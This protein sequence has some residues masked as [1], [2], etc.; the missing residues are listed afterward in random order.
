MKSRLVHT[1]HLYHTELD[2]SRAQRSK[3]ALRRTCSTVQ[4]KIGTQ[5]CTG[6]LIVWQ[7]TGTQ[8]LRIRTKFTA[9]P[10]SPAR[11]LSGCDPHFR[12]SYGVARCADL[13]GPRAAGG[14]SVCCSRICQFC[15]PGYSVG[16]ARAEFAERI[17]K[18]HRI[19]EHSEFT[20]HLS[21][22]RILKQACTSEYPGAFCP[23]AKRAA[24]TV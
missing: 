10:V 15:A 13:R 4:Y 8:I 24:A 23:V 11:K 22:I 12:P 5:Y 2:S 17:R 20:A 21:P 14:N 18:S 7:M 3:D 6:E 9:F 19:R 16:R 1:V